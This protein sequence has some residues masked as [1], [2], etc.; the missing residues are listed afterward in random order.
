MVP[1]NGKI[2]APELAGLGMEIKPEVW[3]H[4][5]AITRTTTA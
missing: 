1:R 3:A 4:P 5:A 2:R